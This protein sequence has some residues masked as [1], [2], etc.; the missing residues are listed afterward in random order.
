MNESLNG[1]A[2][3]FAAGAAGA[4][5]LTAIHQLAREVTGSAPRMDVVGERALA[6]TLDAAGAEVPPEPQLYRWTLAGDLLANSAYYSL[7]ACGP[8]QGLW[9]RAVVYGLAAGVGALVLPRRMGLGDPPKSERVS[10]QIMTVAWYLAGAL[11]AAA[12][13]SARGQTRSRPGSGQAWPKSD[14]TLA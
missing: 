1:W 12:A 4:V 2:K 9:R 14:P 7:V 10:N 5:T 3:A 13:A 8:R 6:S 11:V